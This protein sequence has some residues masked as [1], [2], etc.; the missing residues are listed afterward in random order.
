MVNGCYLLAGVFASKLPR[1]T[2]AINTATSAVYF[3]V[4]K[5]IR[6]NG[7][8]LKIKVGLSCIYKT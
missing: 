3:M 5:A 2:D 6:S 8:G 7:S 1:M 4:P